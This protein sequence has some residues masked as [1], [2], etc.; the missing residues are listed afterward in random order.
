MD[1]F[2]NPWDTTDINDWLNN[3]DDLLPIAEDMR[4][5][6]IV[7]AKALSLQE[8]YRKAALTKIRKILWGTDD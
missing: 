2:K 6:L 3:D 4:S 5:A 1:D 8:E 7:A